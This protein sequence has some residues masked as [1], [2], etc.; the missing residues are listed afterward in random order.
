METKRLIL[1]IAICAVLILGW[2]MLSFH[3][4]W[5]KE[6]A[7][8]ATNATEQ[9]PSQPVGQ[10][11]ASTPAD[12]SAD[13]APQAEKLPVVDPGQTVT[14]ETPLYKA[15]FQ[16]NGAVLYEFH[17]KN[18]NENTLDNS[19]LVNLVSPEA[20]RF[21]PM[22]LLLNGAPT[23]NTGS[24][25]V[26]KDSLVVDENGTGTL[27]FTTTVNNVELVREL[28]FSGANYTI[29]E[30]TYLSTE[31]SQTIKVGYTMGASILPSEVNPSV[32]AYLRY[33]I[34]GGE[35]PKEQ[36]SSYNVTRVAMFENGSF[37][38]LKK[39][40]DLE[41]GQAV[42]G[43][44]SWMGVMNNYFLCAASSSADHTIGRARFQDNVFRVVL[45][46][47]DISLNPGQRAVA[48]ATYF[49]GPK[50]TAKL[51]A[52]PNNLAES[53]YMGMFGFI[54]K[55]L[56]IALNFFYGFLG[57]YGLAIILLTIII[58]IIFWPLS[59][60]SFKSMQEMKRI[61]PM[62][63]KL[64]EK[65]GDDKE[66][67]NR[68]TMALYKTY[69][70]NPMGGCLPMIV[71][72]PVFF[73]LYQALLNSIELRHAAFIKSLPFTDALWLADLSARDPFFITPIVMGLTMLLQQKMS[74]TSGDP[75]QARMMMFMPVIFT[76][77]F[78][79]FPAGLVVYWL[80]NNILSIAQQ[81]LQ[82][83]GTKE[84]G[85]A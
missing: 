23:W 25:S 15:V 44:I 9:A 63:N 1:A 28:T 81:W 7:P 38:E 2:N 75:N 20:A 32:L 45:E 40:S 30:N 36:P 8:A 56:L 69:K 10:T 61:Q 64:R 47:T 18:Y 4:G 57:N 65:Y 85:E 71:Q 54:A 74:P 29:D 3:M 19:P 78:L 33:Y 34:L 46:Q 66:A 13:G 16:A 77:V 68:E 60:K 14:V 73:G 72:L 62:V 43:K 22:G 35:E 39:S 70:I 6:P 24:W 67:L 52:A 83:R 82:L 17:T 31:G 21:A 84:I 37:E 49:I 51:E 27:R 76:V 80:V 53:R 55:P 50:E 48:K 79:N 59:H 58:K 42:T 11:N 12:S 26:D 41:A 5:I